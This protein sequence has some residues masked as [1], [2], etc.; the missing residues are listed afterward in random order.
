MKPRPTRYIS[1]DSGSVATTA[2][3]A[4]PS[5]RIEPGDQRR[6]NA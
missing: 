1:G 3:I 5:C 2:G 4:L 6:Q